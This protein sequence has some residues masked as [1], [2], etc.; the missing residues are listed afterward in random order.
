MPEPYIFYQKPL[1][2][3]TPKWLIILTTSCSLCFPA[4]IAL[5]CVQSTKNND[6]TRSLEVCNRIKTRRTPTDLYIQTK[7][8]KWILSLYNQ[9][10]IKKVSL[11]QNH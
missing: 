11:G 6:I 9:E 1:C 2:Y 5:V 4:P 3:F 8:Y 10:N 7:I